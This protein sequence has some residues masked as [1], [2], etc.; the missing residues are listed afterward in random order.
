[1]RTVECVA[2]M[3]RVATLETF[4]ALLRGINVGGR[5]K[6]PM[7]ELV[8]LFGQAGASDA[9]T[10]IQS[11]N[12]VFKAS[13]RDVAGLPVEVSK[14]IAERFGFEVP[15]MLRSAR[16]LTA[17]VRGNPFVALGADEQKL[18]VMFLADSPSARQRAGLDAARSPPDEF[19]VRASEIYLLCPN[20]VA[21][22][23]LTNAYFDSA[24]ATVST[25]R[26]W[27]TVLKLLELAQS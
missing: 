25:A 3:A 6:L 27:R 17:V 20:G 12:V 23:K 1:M 7:K 15:V 21:R 11:G 26:N 18:H 14:R 8:P 24:L 19:K 16:Q 4:V 10:W 5:N 13:R 2:R 22:T 9:R